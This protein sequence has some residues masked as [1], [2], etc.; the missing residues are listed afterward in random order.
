MG[1][2]C[3]ESWAISQNF[4]RQYL[5]IK[6]NTFKMPGLMKILAM[7]NHIRMK[8]MMTKESLFVFLTLMVNWVK[9]YHL[10]HS[11]IETIKLIVSI[12][13]ADTTW[14]SINTVVCRVLE[15][16]RPCGSYILLTPVQKYAIGKRAAENGTTATLLK[17]FRT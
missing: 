13:E 9:L 17:H 6:L 5:Q 10:E 7:W 3:G 14:L 1:G 4:S 12:D 8:T 11:S 2:K 15:E 16:K